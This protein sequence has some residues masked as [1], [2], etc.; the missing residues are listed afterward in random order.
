MLLANGA[1][2]VTLGERAMQP[3]LAKKNRSLG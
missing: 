2:I 1:K 3:T